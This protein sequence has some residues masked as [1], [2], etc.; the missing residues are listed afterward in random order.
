MFPDVLPCRLT[1]ELSSTVP[2]QILGFKGAEHKR[3]KSRDEAEIFMRNESL[4]VAAADPSKSAGSGQLPQLM[5]HC[6]Y[7]LVGSFIPQAPH[8]T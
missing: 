7:T 2:L 8:I 1:P 4:A 5:D 3:F 6:W